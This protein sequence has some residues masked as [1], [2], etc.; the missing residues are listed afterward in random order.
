VQPKLV[1]GNWRMSGS[2]ARLC[3][4][5]DHMQRERP[6]CEAALCVPHPLLWAAQSAL[7]S[8]PLRWGAQDCSDDD[9][10]F[11]GEVSARMIAEYGPRYVIVGHPQRRARHGESDEQAAHKA[12]RVLAAGMTPIVCVGETESERDDGQAR[13]LLRARL[14]TLVR[15][16]GRGTARAM[17]VYAPAWAVGSRDAAAPGLI[18]DTLGFIAEVLLFERAPP[19]RTLYGGGVGPRNAGAIL[20]LPAVAGVLVG[21]ASLRLADFSDVCRA[22]AA[23]CALASPA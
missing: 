18:D 19:V 11:T 10:A 9:D 22:A 23:A 20:A 16:L 12:Q 17:L 8:T 1:I 7:Q 3:E 13:A 6:R 15:V 14:R 4:F 5:A 2:W 21:G